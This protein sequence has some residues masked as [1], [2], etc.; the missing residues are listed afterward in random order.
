MIEFVCVII[1]FGLGGWAF[2]VLAEDSDKDTTVGLL[3]GSALFAPF[4]AG[5]AVA[6]IFRKRRRAASRERQT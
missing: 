3:F 1:W 2:A 4:L 6:D 5:A